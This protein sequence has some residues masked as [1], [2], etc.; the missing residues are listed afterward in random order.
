LIDR[1]E[2][3]EKAREK[4]LTLGMIEKDYVLGW[5]LF[6]LSGIRELAFKGGTALSKIYFPQIWRLSE[7]LDYVY[8]KD[9]QDIVR[10]LPAI[11]E[12]IEKLSGIKLALKTRHSNP[13]YLQLKI[14]YDAVLGR[15]WIKV[16]VT[17]EAPINRVSSRK[18]SRAYS[19]YPP[20]R[21]RVESVEEMFAEKI[22]SLVERK[23]CRDY[24]D[25]WQLM[26]LKPDR[27]K[28]KKLVERKFQYKE[29]EIK[30]PAEI[31]P[32]DLPEILSGYWGRELGRLIYPLP[33]ME[34]VIH[35][36]ESH[37]R[38]LVKPTFAGG[39]NT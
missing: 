16:D 22:R 15:N 34:T 17:R 9:F 4:N 11:F 24:Y 21:V 19:D 3:L 31:F 26:K 23:K 27:D 38:S 5:L 25:V 30:G 18:V 1:R 7:D 12:R 28:L 33:E 2:L 8:K 36:L 29:M 35:E 20:F 37:L 32:P 10:A 14:Q 6:G 13:E 39:R